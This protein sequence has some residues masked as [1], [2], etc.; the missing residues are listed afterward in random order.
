[1][2][3][4]HW[5]LCSVLLTSRRVAVLAAMLACLL[6]LVGV[7]AVLALDL[8]VDRP[9]D[10]A[11][12]TACTANANDCSLRGAILRANAVAGPHTI[13]VPP[14]LDLLAGGGQ[15]EDAGQTGDLD[16]LQDITINGAGAG[17]TSIGGNQALPEAQRDRVFHVLPAGRLTLRDASVRLGV[18]PNDTAGGTWRGHLCAGA[19]H[20]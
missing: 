13:T 19:A 14:V 2:R 20:P 1:M 12:A 11:G 8:T 16:I 9:D 15:N 10:I 6:W 18:A 4:S 5:L 17:P 3:D 7:D